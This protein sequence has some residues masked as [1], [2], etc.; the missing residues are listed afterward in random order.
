VAYSVYRSVLITARQNVKVTISTILEVGGIALTMILLVALTQLN[1]AL[2]AAISMA[3]GRIASTVYLK[4]SA[5]AVLA[6]R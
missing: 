1:G 2:S 4:W 3:V 5:G 6:H